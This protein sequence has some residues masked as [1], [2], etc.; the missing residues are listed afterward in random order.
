MSQDFQQ[1]LTRAIIFICLLSRDNGC[2][3][4]RDR[5]ESDMM[6]YAG[7]GWRW[8]EMA[9]MSLFHTKPGSK[10]TFFG[11]VRKVHEV[12]IHFPIFFGA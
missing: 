3:G 10:Y 6:R 5:L 2:C 8:L 12:S 4:M 9:G 11:K 1:V 7:D